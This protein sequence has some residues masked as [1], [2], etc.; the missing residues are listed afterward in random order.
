MRP[1]TTTVGSKPAA[2]STVAT[3]EVVVVLP[4][5]PAMAMPYFTAHQLGQH[6]CARN[7]GNAVQPGF[8][9]LG[10][11]VVDRARVHDD[12]G[13]V[14]VLGVVTMSTRTPSR[15]RFLVFSP[16]VDRSPR[17]RTRACAGFRP[18][19]SCRCRRPP[20]KCTWRTRPRN[21]SKPPARVGKRAGVRWDLRYS[22]R[23]LRAELRVPSPLTPKRSRAIAFAA[24]GD[25]ARPRALPSPS[26]AAGRARRRQLPWRCALAWPPPTVSK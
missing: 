10:I 17:R 8:P 14:H 20:M 11:F 24:C 3:S 23:E 21:I 16:R 19:R 9:H 2:R 4:C 18:A 7:D 26:G 15:S 25:R 22:H 12:I 1:P 6:F 5:E 13:A